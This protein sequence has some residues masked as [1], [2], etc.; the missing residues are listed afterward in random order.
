MCVRTN[1]AI[2]SKYSKKYSRVEYA[3]MGLIAIGVTFFM[4]KRL[5]LYPTSELMQDIHS[6]I[7]LSVL[8][9]LSLTILSLAFDGYTGSTQDTFIA[10][11]KPSTQQLMFYVSKTHYHIRQSF[12]FYRIP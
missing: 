12:R 3:R 11:H 9:G 2:I 1:K 5:D 4:L 10:K 8:I 6:S 7:D